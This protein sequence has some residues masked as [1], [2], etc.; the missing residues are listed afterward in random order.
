MLIPF[1][2]SPLLPMRSIVFFFGLWIPPGNGADSPTM[3]LPERPAAAGPPLREPPRYA[4]DAS[5]SPDGSCSKAVPLGDRR[6]WIKVKRKGHSKT[7]DPTEHDPV[8]R[9]SPLSAFGRESAEELNV[10]LSREILDN[11][12]FRL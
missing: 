2:V 9:K 11:R 4:P 5:R 3:A 8:Q 12:R 7:G 6:W 1:R 10:E